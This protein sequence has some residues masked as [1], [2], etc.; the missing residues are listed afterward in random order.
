M[1]ERIKTALILLIVVGFAIF[2][3]KNPT[4]MVLLM[5]VGTLIAANEWSKL[6]PNLKNRYWLISTMVV[7]NFLT[8]VFPAI[9]PYIWGVSLLMWCMAAYWVKLYPNKI[10]HWYKK[11]I[12]MPYG[13]IIIAATISGMFYLWQQSAWWLLYAMLLVWCADSGAYFAGR[14]FGKYKLA[15]NVSPK[16]TYEGLVGGLLLCAVV[17]FAVATYVIDLADDKLVPFFVLSLFAVGISVLGDLFESMIK[18][19]AGVK[20]SGNIL[21]GHGGLL[22]RID[23][24]MATVPLF[25]FGFWYLNGF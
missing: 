18:R 10:T 3:T 14:A 6:V 5:S 21:P 22:D 13:I 20:D 12:L 9:A 16:K 17:I 8:F 11:A 4:P 24:L 23:S 15:P 2:A 7:V 1:F 19:K 25:A